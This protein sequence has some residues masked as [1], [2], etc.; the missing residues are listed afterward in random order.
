MHEQKDSH[1]LNQN[2]YFDENNHL[3]E[4]AILIFVQALLE[5]KQKSPQTQDIDFEHLDVPE[6]ILNHVNHCD[7][8]RSEIL[9]FY[10]YKKDSA[11]LD[12]DFVD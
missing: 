5:E 10:F 1:R 3:N 2:Q 11:S 4:T 9:R 7:A 12:S 8:C 6:E